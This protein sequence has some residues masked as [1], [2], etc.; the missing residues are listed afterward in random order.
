MSYAAADAQATVQVFHV[1][2]DPGVLVN[3]YFPATGGGWIQPRFWIGEANGSLFLLDSE[4]DAWL[5]QDDD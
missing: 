1:T 3:G 2:D 4:D 5:D